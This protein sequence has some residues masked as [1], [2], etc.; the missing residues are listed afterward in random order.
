MVRHRL[1]L[2]LCLVLALDGLDGGWEPLIVVAHPELF[3][4][5]SRLQSDAASHRCAPTKQL[6]CAQ[7]TQSPSPAHLELRDP[8]FLFRI[9]T[10]EGRILRPRGKEDADEVPSSVLRV[11]VEI[12]LVLD[13]LSCD[14]VE[15]LLVA[16][17]AAGNSANIILGR[18]VCSALEDELS[19]SGDFPLS[20]LT[21][22]SAQGTTLTTTCPNLL[23]VVEAIDSR[24]DSTGGKASK[25]EKVK[26]EDKS[27]RTK[28]EEEVAVVKSWR[29]ELGALIANWS[30]VRMEDADNRIYAP[31]FIAQ[32]EETTIS[33]DFV[34]GG[35]RKEKTEPTVP[36]R[37]N[38]QDGPQTFQLVFRG[39]VSLE[40]STPLAEGGENISTTDST[41]VVSDVASI[42]STAITNIFAGGETVAATND[43]VGTEA[44]SDAIADAF[45]G[46][47]AE[48]TADIA[49]TETVASVQSDVSVSVTQ[50]VQGEP[51]T[52]VVT[53]IVTQTEINTAIET[54]VNT[55]TADA[56]QQQAE[57][58]AAEA[59]QQQAQTTST[60]TSTSSPTP[61][62][63][64]QNAVDSY[65]CDNPTARTS[66]ETTHGPIKDWTFDST[67]TSF[68]GLFSIIGGSCTAAKYQAFNADIAGWTFPGVTTMNFMFDGATSFNQDLSSWA[69]N[70]VTDMSSMF[71]GASDFNSPLFSDTAKV[72]TMES[73]FK[74][75]TSFNQNVA[76]MNVD[77][78]ADMR[79]MFLGASNFNQNLCSWGTGML[80][81]PA[82]TGT[83]VEDM[84]IN[85]SCGD[86][87]IPNVSGTYVTPICANCPNPNP[88]PI[89]NAIATIDKFLCGTA[90]EKTTVI[91]THGPIKDWTFDSSV[92]SFE[93]LFSVTTHC[94]SNISP[95]PRPCASTYYTNFNEDLSG[96]SAPGVTTMSHMFAASATSSFNNGGATMFDLPPN[97]NDMSNMF[98]FASSFN[99]D[100][101]SW[102]PS[103]VQ[104]MESMFEGATSFN[105]GGN[106]GGGGVCAVCSGVGNVK[107]MEA[108]FK[109]ATSFNID[110]SSWSVNKVITMESMFEGA[111]DF[112]SPPPSATALVIN[113]ANMFKDCINF[114]KSVNNMVVG[115]VLDMSKM[116]QGA[117]AYNNADVDFADSFINSG[118][119]QTMEG[120]FQDAPNFVGGGIQNLNVGNVANMANMFKGA[121]SFQQ[122]LCEWGNYLDLYTVSVTDMFAGTNCGGSSFGS[123]A[124]PVF[125]YAIGVMSPL[126]KSCY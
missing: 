12:E 48:A 63:N 121:S 39:I 83:Y 41:G 116:F 77:K 15:Q 53:A 91:N 80:A 52:V 54:T 64:A 104:S 57:A 82:I 74:S 49:S 16:G 35:N 36:V 29:S 11:D 18:I 5:T 70:K 109:G 75:A 97:V 81:T 122:D 110:I 55:N 103:N 113:M 79:E 124:D 8:Q 4:T 87:G 84:F 17:I 105:N 65:I 96:W 93:C 24:V 6:K 108:M 34:D 31:E 7:R 68:T 50:V 20:L 30:D 61:V 95:S 33:N 78:V 59:Q 76:S 58:E 120:M 14:T 9:A 69:T 107:T 72:T 90:T 32:V 71:E 101:T 42:F 47:T 106:T 60:S 112:D 46:L 86:A 94:S 19:E 98:Q 119:V 100:L 89:T 92:D 67:V 44:L 118:N 115:N 43:V 102:S 111:S 38:L 62:A 27:S 40:A 13:G 3:H 21:G 126:C 85:T 56:A 37:R 117:I 45:P 51:T 28:E 123:T 10:L 2:A 22:C 114:D 73:M 66:I 1:V 23:L 25:A 99:Q 125:N 88:T 26:K